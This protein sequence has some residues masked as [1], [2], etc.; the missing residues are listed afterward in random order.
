MARCGCCLDGDHPDVALC[1]DT[2]KRWLLKV[3]K[4][5]AAMKKVAKPCRPVRGLER[6]IRMRFIKDFAHTLREA[7]NAPLFLS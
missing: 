3:P 2:I 5:L 1:K 6:E 7:L 4:R